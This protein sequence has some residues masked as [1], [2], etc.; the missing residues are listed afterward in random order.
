MAIADP[1]K[2]Q[3]MINLAAEAAVKLQQA[4]SDLEDVRTKFQQHDP[5][6]TGTPL[7]DNVAAVNDWINDVV[8]VAN[9]NVADAMIEARRLHH[10]N[11]ALE[12]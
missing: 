12:D 9:A 4:A 5:D 6:T 8:N 2:C 3:T 7:K 1:K 10:K 11:K